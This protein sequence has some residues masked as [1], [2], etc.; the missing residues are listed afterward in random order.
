MA[1]RSD[2]GR[3]FQEFQQL[4]GNV[5]PTNSEVVQ[6]YFY[7]RKNLTDSHSKFLNKTPNFADIRD[8]LEYVH[9]RSEMKTGRNEKT[10]LNR[11]S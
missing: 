11:F 7:L 6:H 5:L 1:R 2:I 9:M 3:S 10:S 8:S 4:S